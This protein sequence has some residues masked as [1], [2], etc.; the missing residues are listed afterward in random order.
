MNQ[1][2]L[3]SDREKKKKKDSSKY[4]TYLHFSHGVGSHAPRKMAQ[5]HLLPLGI[6]KALKLHAYLLWL[7]Q[8]EP[9]VPKY[10][11]EGRPINKV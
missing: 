7:I 2:Y 10:Q 6:C 1:A 3:D 8:K 11:T 4:L 9:D 5:F